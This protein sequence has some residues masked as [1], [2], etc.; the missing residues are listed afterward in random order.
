MAVLVLLEPTWWRKVAFGAVAAGLL[1]VYFRGSGYE[2][3]AGAIPAFALLVVLYPRTWIG[4]R[5]Q[6]VT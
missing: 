4:R 5:V 6:E 2:A 3:A 1:T